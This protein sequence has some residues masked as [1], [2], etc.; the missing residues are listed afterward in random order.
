MF[1]PSYEKS[2]TA[3]EK[4]RSRDIYEEDIEESAILIEETIDSVSKTVKKRGPKKKKL[5]TYD[6]VLLTL[7]EKEAHNKNNQ[8]QFRLSIPPALEEILNHQEILLLAPSFKGPLPQL[9]WQSN[10]PTVARI[11]ENF[12]NRQEDQPIAQYSHKSESLPDPT[13]SL[14]PNS[15]LKVINNPKTIFHSISTLIEQLDPDKT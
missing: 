3:E 7:P 2:G 8:F 13:R 12:S 10:L 15:V 11:L 5:E 4:K 9:P 6:E 14:P 1:T